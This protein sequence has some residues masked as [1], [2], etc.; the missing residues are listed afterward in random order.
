MLYEHV[1]DG[2]DAVFANQGVILEDRGGERVATLLSGAGP[3]EVT[4]GPAA[5]WPPEEFAGRVGSALAF[6]DL[7]G[8]ARTNQSPRPT[9]LGVRRMAG[10]HLHYDASTLTDV[11]QLVDAEGAFVI[12]RDGRV[13][14]RVP[15]ARVVPIPGAPWG[16]FVTDTDGVTWLAWGA[17]LERR[18]PAGITVEYGNDD[19]WV[20]VTGE[21]D[22]VVGWLDVY[23][24]LTDGLFDG[25]RLLPSLSGPPAGRVSASNGWAIRDGVPY[26]ISLLQIAEVAGP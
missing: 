22:A 5:D 19:H 15:G 11:Y 4:L 21:G 24:V 17:A 9:D 14:H 8:F 18:A 10:T 26:E 20:G 3:E 12:L 2:D 23:G 13:E 6:V 16:A 25:S 7:Q 1:L